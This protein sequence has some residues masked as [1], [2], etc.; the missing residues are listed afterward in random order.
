VS[1]EDGKKVVKVLEAGKPVAREVTVGR[2][3]GDRTEIK[4]GLKEGES[5]VL[6]GE[7]K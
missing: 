4:S 5:V 7:S 6:P 3:S 1:E 2:S